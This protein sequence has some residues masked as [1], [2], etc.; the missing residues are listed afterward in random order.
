[1]LIFLAVCAGVLLVAWTAGRRGRWEIAANVLTVGGDY[2]SDSAFSMDS[3]WLAVRFH[4][5]VSLYERLEGGWKKSRIRS[6][7]TPSDFW[8]TLL[9]ATSSVLVADS[10]DPQTLVIVDLVQDAVVAQT[11][12]P[13]PIQSLLALREGFVE[14]RGPGKKDVAVYRFKDDRLTS[15]PREVGEFT[16]RV[17]LRNGFVLGFWESAVNQGGPWRI[18]DGDEVRPFGDAKAR[19]EWI[20]GA[21]AEGPSTG[22]VTFQRIGRRFRLRSKEGV[23]LHSW[24]VEAGVDHW[25]QAGRSGGWIGLSKSPPAIQSAKFG[26]EP[27]SRRLLELQAGD[28]SS[29]LFSNDDAGVVW[30]F[31]SSH[32]EMY[33]PF[34]QRLDSPNRQRWTTGRQAVFVHTDGSQPPVRFPIKHYVVSA[35]VDP[36]GRWAVVA[37]PGKGGAFHILDLS[38]P[39][40]RRRKGRRGNYAALRAQQM[41]LFVASRP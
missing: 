36:S 27:S 17:Y 22:V 35:C 40:N 4:Q 33:I 38:Q 5:N 2:P 29:W 19:D 6:C 31:V 41:L 1:V 3:H 7:G 24:T 12:T 26:D 20:V 13:F 18:V 14:A 10:T 8:Q 28:E 16:R 25:V 9:P 37:D 11:K 15:L 23:E 30:A 34:M 32:W 21:I 39:N